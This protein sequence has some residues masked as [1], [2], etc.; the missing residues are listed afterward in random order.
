MSIAISSKFN[1]P[2][3]LREDGRYE[4]TLPVATEFEQMLRDNAME[5]KAKQAFDR[6]AQRR[7]VSWLTRMRL[8]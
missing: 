7:H 5:A 1:G 8:R 4:A 6:V 3:E 2:R